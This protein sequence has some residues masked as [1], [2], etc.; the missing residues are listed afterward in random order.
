MHIALKIVLAVGT[1][2]AATGFAARDAQAQGYGDRG[3]PQEVY[4]ASNDTR[5]SRCQMPWRDS[6]LTRQMSKAACIEP[7]LGQRSL[8]RV[9]QGRLPRQLR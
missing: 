6:V 4:C 9:D 7:D 2:L 8:Q 3:Q 5:G 1:L